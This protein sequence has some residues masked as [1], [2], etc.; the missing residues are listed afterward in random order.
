MLRRPGSV[1]HVRRRRD[2]SAKT[3]SFAWRRS[4]FFIGVA[5]RRACNG[6]HFEVAW[7]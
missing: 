7:F 6:L 4:G 1:R 2:S 3:A 5:G